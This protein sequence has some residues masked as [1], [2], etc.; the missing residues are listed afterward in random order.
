MTNAMTVHLRLIN[1]HL[2][3]E[4]KDINKVHRS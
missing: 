2:D 4:L 1:R 3:K